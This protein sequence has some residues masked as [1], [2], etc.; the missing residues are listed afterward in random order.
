MLTRKKKPY[1]TFVVIEGLY[2][3][4][5]DIAPLKE[6]VAMKNEYFFRIIMDDSLGVGTLGKTGRGTCEYWDVPTSAVDVLTSSLSHALGS[7]ADFVRV[8]EQW[9]FISA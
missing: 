9:S 8:P 1:R 5:G 6:I 3:N 7:V 2:Q 4:Y